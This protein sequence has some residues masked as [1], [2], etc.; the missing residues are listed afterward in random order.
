M[1]GSARPLTEVFVLFMY[2]SVSSA[3]LLLCSHCSVVSEAVN[4]RGSQ[5]VLLSV[6][7]SAPGSAD[8]PSSVLPGISLAFSDSAFSWTCC[9]LSVLRGFA[10]PSWGTFMLTVDPCPLHKRLASRDLGRSVLDRRAPTAVS[11]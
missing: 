4:D 8:A 10:D 6:H 3:V 2:I 1:E 9:S 5:P 7:V 11:L